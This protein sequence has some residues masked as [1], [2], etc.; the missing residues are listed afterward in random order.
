RLVWSDFLWMAR[1]EVIMKSKHGIVLA[2]VFTLTLISISAVIKPQ[3]GSSMDSGKAQQISSLSTVEESEL[4]RMMPIIISW[5]VDWS[6][7]EDPCFDG[8]NIALASQLRNIQSKKVR[9]IIELTKSR[10]YVTL[11]E[12]HHRFVFGRTQ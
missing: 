5:I 9:A 7:D 4:L 3:D 11:D 2:I 10:M 12:I 6:S 1:V 8:G